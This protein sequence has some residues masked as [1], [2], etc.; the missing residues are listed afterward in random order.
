MSATPAADETTNMDI[1]DAS[2]AHFLIKIESFS[3]L[4]KCRVGKYETKE[5]VAGEYKWRLVIYPNGD[6]NNG[7][8]C[9]Y[10]SVKLAMV[11]TSSMP[12]N[13]EVNANFSIL[14]YNWISGDYVSS[15]GRT[16]RFQRT[17]SEWG[18]SKFIS[19]KNMFDASNGYIMNDNCVFGAEVFVVKREAVTECLSLK[20]IEIVPYK[21][22]FKISK[23]QKI[24]GF[25]ESEKFSA[26]GYKWYIR[27]FPKGNAA[28]TGRAISIFLYY[29]CSDFTTHSALVNATYTVFI[30]NQLY[31]THIKRS[32]TYSFSASKLQWGWPAFAELATI[33]DPKKGFIVRDCMYL[34]IELSVLNNALTF[35]S[36][37]I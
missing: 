21:H 31:G 18:F 3:L 9:D 11:Y 33:D 14:L 36:T 16:R 7:K 8:E 6:N 37:W 17:Q 12:K 22:D 2:P 4:D 13:W 29:D 27:I 23:F 5:F 24:E 35:S 26:G 25:W 28:A 32:L 19:K 20:S 15:L 1:R 30:K 34:N 10:I